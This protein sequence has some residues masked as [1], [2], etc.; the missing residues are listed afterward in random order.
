MATAIGRS[1][2][3]M[4]QPARRSSYEVDESYNPYTDAVENL[5]EASAITGA[6]LAELHG[7]SG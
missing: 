3:L 4:V 2:P 5:T 7:D 1:L 6:M